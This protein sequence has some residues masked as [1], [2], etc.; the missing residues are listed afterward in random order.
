MKLNKHFQKQIVIPKNVKIEKNE[1][2]LFFH[3]PL[4]STVIDLKK[5][6][7]TGKGAFRLKATTLFLFSHCKAFLGCIHSLLKNKIYG[8][9]RGFLI[10]TRLVGIGYRVQ[11]EN[12]TSPTTQTS[13][14]LQTQ[15]LTFK[16]GFSHD[17]LYKLPPT[18]RVFLIEPTLLC[19]YG[20]H[21][22]QLTQTV[23]KIRQLKKPSVYKGKGLRL[24]D[25]VVSLKEGKRK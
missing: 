13:S 21:K 6:D 11:L 22:N 20:I 24:L 9:T 12:S 16:L 4:G 14:E 7:P 5:I 3:G 2:F 25:E 18:V 10:Y 8:V 15:T 17:F 23:S 1:T 19:F